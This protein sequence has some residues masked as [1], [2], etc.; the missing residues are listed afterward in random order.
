M[1]ELGKKYDC[2]NGSNVDLTLNANTTYYI[3]VAQEDY[4]G[5]YTLKINKQM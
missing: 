1:E 3:V 4:T 5:T 2:K